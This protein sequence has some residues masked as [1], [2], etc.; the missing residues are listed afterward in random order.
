M[1][2]IILSGYEQEDTETMDLDS[3]EDFIRFE[4]SSQILQMLFNFQRPFIIHAG[5]YYQHFDASW[6]PSDP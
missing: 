1:Y 6:I 5:Q 4:N 2:S 3:D